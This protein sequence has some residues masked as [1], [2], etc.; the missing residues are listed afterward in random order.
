[1]SRKLNIKLGSRATFLLEKILVML[2]ASRKPAESFGI[3]TPATL[4]I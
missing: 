1:M 3:R 4:S 2:G